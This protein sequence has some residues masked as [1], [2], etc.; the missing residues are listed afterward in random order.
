MAAQRL[1][2]ILIALLVVSTLLAL[3]APA[4]Q[5]DEETST[6]EQ[7][8]TAATPP[9]QGAVI[10]RELEVEPDRRTLELDAEVGDRLVL[11]V[12]SEQTRQVRVDP[13]GLLSTA[14]RASPA[15]FDILLNQPG[16]VSVT[17][18]DLADPVAT[19]K[20]TEPTDEDEQK[21]GPPKKKEADPESTPRAEQIEA[22][23]A[24][25]D[26]GPILMGA[27]LQAVVP[28]RTA[29]LADSR[30]IRCA[31]PAPPAGA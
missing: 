1:V 13:L 27:A 15:R 11:T 6:T 5:T 24:A 30:L 25:F 31:A 2:A 8:T 17:S 29:A 23:T 26:G 18:P 4:E 20:V 9:P 12:T 22:P 19:F 3:L 7:S 28:H 10:E 16:R 14:G 21:A